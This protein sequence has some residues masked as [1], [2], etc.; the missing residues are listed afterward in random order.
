VL[1]TSACKNVQELEL[2][3]LSDLNINIIKEISFIVLKNKKHLK[4]KA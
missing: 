2:Q 4:I 3:Y 1:L